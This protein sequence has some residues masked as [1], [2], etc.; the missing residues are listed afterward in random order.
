MK[1]VVCK[2]S[3]CSR[4]RIML[5]HEQGEELVRSIHTQRGAMDREWQMQREREGDEA[6]R[7]REQETG[8]AKEWGKGKGEERESTQRAR[9]CR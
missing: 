4:T 3:C 2:T 8:R 6:S 5:Y 1:S 7:E 9:V